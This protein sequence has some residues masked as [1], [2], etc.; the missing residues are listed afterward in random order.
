M[1]P[2]SVEPKPLPRWVTIPLGLV[3]FPF[4][5][6]C[7]VGSAI[8]LLAPNVPPSFFTVSI[9]T[10]FLGGSLWVSLLSFRLIISNP[11]KSKGLVSPLALR[12]IGVLF[13]SMLILSIFVGTFMDKPIIYSIQT[14]IYFCVA[15]Q[16]FRMAKLRASNQ[17]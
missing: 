15:A 5:L 13:I 11:S 2:E 7:V 14:I 10:L 4:T 8:L 3:L 12:L 16:L 6:M 9:A 17:V 1:E